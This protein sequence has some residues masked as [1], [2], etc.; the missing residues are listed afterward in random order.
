MVNNALNMK[1]EIKTKS[2]TNRP[3][4]LFGEKNKKKTKQ[5]KT[6]NLLQNIGQ[7]KLKQHKEKFVTLLDTLNE[8]YKCIHDIKTK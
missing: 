3:E 1:T 6:N 5:T 8:I 7:A 2:L 4:I